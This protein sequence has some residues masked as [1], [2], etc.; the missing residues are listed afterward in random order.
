MSLREGK[1]QT[2]NSKGCACSCSRQELETGRTSET[3]RRSSDVR[4]QKPTNVHDGRNEVE[5]EVR[6]I[7]G[8][9]NSAVYVPVKETEIPEV[10]GSGSWS[11][12]DKQKYC[13]ITHYR[14][15]RSHKGPDS[16][17]NIQERR[18]APDLL[19]GMDYF[20]ELIQLDRITSAYSG[21]C[22]I[23]TL[24]GEVTEKRK[25]R[26]KFQRPDYN[27]DSFRRNRL[28]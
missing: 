22:H 21:L 12:S 10:V 19:I 1:G 6:A 5:T 18:V 13:R 2:E 8:R 27:D 14:C 23:P 4:F 26:E 17:E 25:S 15:L 24:L 16:S 7:V 9:N 28:C 11:F 3:V 20:F